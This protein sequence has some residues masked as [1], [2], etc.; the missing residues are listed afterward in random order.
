MT[1]KTSILPRLL[2][3]LLLAVA[4]S[5]PVLAQDAAPARTLDQAVERV[6]R[7]TGGRVLAAE[8]RRVGRKIEYRVKV[9]T[10]AGHVRV[11]VVPGDIAR[12]SSAPPPGANSGNL[13]PVDSRP[14]PVIIDRG[15]RGNH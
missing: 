7:D 12:S 3:P 4:P 14:R 8:P 5:V 15:N 6:Q 9:L 1:P 10:P 13:R 2:L 11:V